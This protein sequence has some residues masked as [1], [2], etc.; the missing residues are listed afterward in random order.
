LQPASKT[1]HASNGIVVR[2]TP[3]FRGRPVF[4]LIWG[5]SGHWLVTG[6]AAGLAPTAGMVTY[7]ALQQTGLAIYGSRAIITVVPA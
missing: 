2:M 6:P 4:G 7:E 1:A 5:R 3:S